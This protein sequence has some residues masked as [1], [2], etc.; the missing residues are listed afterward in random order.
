MFS[1][2]GMVYIKHSENSRPVLDTDITILQDMFPE[3]VMKLGKIETYKDTKMY[4]YRISFNKRRASNKRRPLISAA[5]L[6]VHIEI[7]AS[8]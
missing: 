7:S 3:F 4:N 2:N 5:V 1:K 6:G 8:L